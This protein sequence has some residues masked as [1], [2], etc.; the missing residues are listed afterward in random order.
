MQTTEFL[1]K[2][3]R[4][5]APASDATLD[6]AIALSWASYAARQFDTA[7]ALARGCLHCWPDE[8]RLAL[9][10]WMSAVELSQPYP[11]PDCALPQGEPWRRLVKAT[12]ARIAMAQATEAA[13]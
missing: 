12:Q 6:S 4:S 13:P 10:A 5:Q 7:F 2:P 3:P 11:M 9:L 8:P 1:R